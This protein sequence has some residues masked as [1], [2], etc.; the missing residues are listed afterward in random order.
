VETIQA[1]IFD[2]GGVL[3]D[4]HFDRVTSAFRQLS[5]GK[6]QNILDEIKGH[7]L[8]LDFESGLLSEE[9]FRTGLRENFEVVGSDEELDEGWNSM[10][11]EFSAEKMK[12]VQTLASQKRVFLLSNT[13]SIHEGSFS[14]THRRQFHGRELASLFERAYY[15]HV[16]KDRK[17]LVSIYER[18][19]EENSLISSDTLFIDDSAVNIEGAKAAGLRTFHYKIGSGIKGFP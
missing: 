17:P 1:V 8:F 7:P 19:I 18:V 2:L 3:L 15:S 6:L 5:K 12:Y 16:V 9:Q 10:L 14:E 4:L 13:N 11:G